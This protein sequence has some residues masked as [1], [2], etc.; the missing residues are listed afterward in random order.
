MG[1]P[2]KQAMLDILEALHIPKIRREERRNR[3]RKE[4]ADNNLPTLLYAYLERLY[5]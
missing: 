4:M 5:T 3:G 1:N 2:S